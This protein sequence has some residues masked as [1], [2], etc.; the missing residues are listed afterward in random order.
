[1]N[2]ILTRAP[3]PSSVRLLVGSQM[4][5]LIHAGLVLGSRPPVEPALGLLTLLVSLTAAAA[6]VGAIAGESGNTSPYLRRSGNHES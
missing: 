1:M 6:L 3:A 5:L 4:L 2:G